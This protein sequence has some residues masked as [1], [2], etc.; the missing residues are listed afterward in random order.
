VWGQGFEVPYRCS[1]L[2]N[3]TQFIPACFCIKM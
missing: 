1:S 2:P 3:V